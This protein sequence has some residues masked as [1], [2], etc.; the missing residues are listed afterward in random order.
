MALR[1][2]VYQLLEA[3]DRTYP[4]ARLVDLGLIV[5]ILLNLVA[6]VLESVP[7]V[8]HAWGAA[9]RGFEVFSVA[10]FTVEYLLRLWS[11]PENPRFTAHDSLGSARLRYLATPLAIV[12]LLAILP[13]YLP[14][15]LGVDL[16]FL[17]ALR[18]LRVFKLTRYFSA[19]GVLLDVLREEARAFGAAIFVLLVIMMMASSAMYL[20]EHE[21]QPEAF[22][23]IPAAMWWA[24][25][26]LTTVG[27]GDV[28]PITVGG[29][30][31]GACITVIGIGMVALPAGILASGFSDHLHARK[32]RYRDRVEVAIAD[33]R[34][35]RLE[36]RQLEV[37]REQLA[38]SE[39]DAEDIL[40]EVQQP[41][42]RG[43]CPCCKRPLDGD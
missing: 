24:V 20:F 42:A 12:D 9:F 11:S 41:T 27:Y 3:P 4:G 34:L 8:G 15:L 29:K 30:I 2:D 5:L 18:L 33:G 39:R 35:S 31:F 21:A 13:F 28:T 26:T 38:L 40:D 1:Q 17:R 22:G 16:R 36:Q 19:M 32:R 7:K 10:V 25:A 14:F 6:I 37:A 23:S 43:V